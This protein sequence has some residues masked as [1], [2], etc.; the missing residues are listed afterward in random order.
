LK[1]QKGKRLDSN[2]KDQDFIPARK[3]PKM[4]GKE[5]S[6]GQKGETDKKGAHVKK[7]R[8]NFLKEEGQGGFAGSWKKKGRSKEKKLFEK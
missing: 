1:N 6:N 2:W 7:N 4:G 5:P 8:K 3:K